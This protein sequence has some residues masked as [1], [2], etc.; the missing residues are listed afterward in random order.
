MQNLHVITKDEKSF[1]IKNKKFMEDSNLLTFLKKNQDNKN[2]I[3]L[4]IN[5]SDLKD[6]LFFYQDEFLLSEESWNFE[7]EKFD[8]D[9]KLMLFENSKYLNLEIFIH[10][11]FIYL[12][13][14]ILVIDL[15]KN[16]NEISKETENEFEN[17][18]GKLFRENLKKLIN[19]E[20]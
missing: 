14:Q 9:K 15:I 1:N 12:K 20:L 13:K 6:L 17:N 5:C 4:E 10:R 16:K 19:Y 11:F 8:D 3:F 2:Q 18:Y 7:F